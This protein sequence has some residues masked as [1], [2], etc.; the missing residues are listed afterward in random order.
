MKI[1]R[2]NFW[3]LTLLAGAFAFAACEQKNKPEDAKEIANDQNEAKFDDT[4][5]ENDTEWAVAVA[6]LGMLEVEASRL[7]LERATTPAVKQFAQRMVDDHTKAN[8]ELKGLASQKNISLPATLSDK[9]Q[10]KL[11]DLREKTGKDFEDAYTDCMVKDHKEAVDKFKKQA[12]KGDDAE[13][14]SWAA[15]K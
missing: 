8:E 15:G 1:T 9:S 10:K 7:A 12:E 2:N 6:D 3:L 14:K 4:E 11:S 5:I 13:L